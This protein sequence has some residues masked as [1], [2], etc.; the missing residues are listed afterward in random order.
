MK[1]KVWGYNSSG[2]KVVAHHYEL[3][4]VSDNVFYRVKE[5]STHDSELDCLE[6]IFK[7][8]NVYFAIDCTYRRTLLREDIKSKCQK[9]ADD[10]PGYIADVIQAGGFISLLHIKVFEELGLET[11]PLIRQREKYQREKQEKI[12]A[13]NREEKIR[14]EQKRKEKE[15]RRQ[16]ELVQA[17]ANFL[18]GNF[19]D[20]EDFLDLCQQHGV[21]L[22][23]RTVGTIR[24]S[25]PEISP[26]SAQQRRLKSGGYA[27][28]DG[29]FKAI[30]A[31]LKALKS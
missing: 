2:D 17:T 21:P 6:V 26:H 14:E 29:C 3:E 28:T 23:I 22:T 8:G 9:I 31:L 18:A 16:K 19:I 15:E 30:D 4:K 5:P 12:A 27:S 11:A 24:S 10:F 25:I 1:I 13:C 7:T 20:S